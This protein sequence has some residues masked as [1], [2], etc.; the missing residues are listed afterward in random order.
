MYGVFYTLQDVPDPL[1][2]FKESYF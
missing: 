2:G 1:A